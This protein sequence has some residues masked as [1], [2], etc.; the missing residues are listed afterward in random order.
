MDLIDDRAVLD[1]EEDDESFDEETGEVREKSNGANGHFD[2]SSEEEEDDDDEEAAAEV[3]K[4]FIVDEDEDDEETRRERRRERKKRRREE[5]EDEGLDEEDLELIGLKPAEEAPEPKFKRLKRGP[6]EDRDVQ[7]PY[8][9]NDIFGHSDEEEEAVDYSRRTSR[10]DRRGLQ[11]EFDDFIE[12]DVF[13]DEEQQRQ[14]EDEEV[15]RPNRRGLP[16][17]GIADAAGLDEQALEDFRAAFGDGTDYDFALEKEDEADEEEAERD[18]HLD[19]KDVF[20]P[21]Q[22]AEKMLTDEDNTIRYTDEAE[23]HQ[24]A[25][26]PYRHVELSEDEFK[27]EA[28]WISN[29]MLP[30]KQFNADLHEPFRRAV[31]QVLE[32][33]VRDDYEVPFIFQNR[34]DYLL[35]VVQRVVGRE[36]DGTPRTVSDATRL[37]VQRDLWQIFEHDLKYRALIEKRQ[38]LRKAYEDLKSVNIPEDVMFQEMLPLAATMEELQDLQDYLYFQYASRLK[39]LALTSHGETNGINMSQK[40]AATKTVYEEIRGAKAYGLV[41]AFGITA[42]AFAQ[43]AARKGVRTY[44]EDPTDNPENLADTF[45]DGEFPTGSRVLKAAKSMF[46]EELVMSPRFRGLIR[47]NVYKE[48]VIDC[49]RTEKG[50]RK[51][52][53]QHPYYEFKYLRNQ[54][55]GSFFQRPDLFLKM[56]KAE[57]EGLVE[58]Q[59]RLRNNEN[60]KKQL[61]KHIETDNYSN[62][63]D[64]W[65]AER[66]EVI[67]VAVD[68]VMKLMGRLV[69]EN[70]KEQCEN[71]IGVECREEFN[72]R[73]DQAP[74]QPRGMKKGTTPRVLTLS[75]GGGVPGRDMIYW[76]FVND[77]GRVLEHGRFKELGPGDRE[78]GIPDGKDVEALLEVIRR[79]EPEVIGVSGWCPDTRKLHSNLVTLVKNHDL[80]G[81][82]F[83]D[84]D[85]R[86]RSELLEVVMVNDEVARMYQT[87]DR[88]KL[89]HPGFPQLALYCV[90]L[91]RYLQDPLKEYAALGRD[92]V[93]VSF[94]PAQNLL[95]QEKLLKKLEMALVDNVNMVGVDLNEAASDTAV[96]NLLPYVAGLGPRKA[97]HL[98][99]VIHLNGG[100]VNTR[101]DLLG[102]N[103]LHAAMGFKVWSNAAATLYIQF[104]PSEPTSEY[105]DN[106][107]VHPEDYDIARKMAADALEL[108]EEDIEAERQE[109]GSG[110]IV[111]RLIREEAQERVNDLVLEEYAEQLE[112]NL[113]SKKH[114]TLE[115]IRAELIEPYEELRNP[116]RSNLG[117][118]E[119]F[120]MLT[121]ETRDS[122][123]RGMNVPIS[124][125]KITDMHVEGKLDSGLDAVVEEG[126]WADSTVS[127]KQ[128]YTLHQT[129]Q[130]HI[131]AINRK[132]FTVSVSLRDDLLKKPFK[133]YNHSDR[134][135]DEW[136][137][138]EEAADKKLLEEKTDSGN[139]AA[140]V[141]KHPLFRPFNAKQAEE[142]LG[143]QNR[144]D[145]VI[146]PSSKG[147]DHLAVTWKVADGIFQHI[148][149]L[150][151]DKENEFSLGRT[152]RIGGRYNYSDLDEL[153]VLHVK[154]MARKVDEM[155]G[156]EKFQDKSKAA[157]EEWLT[158]Y[159]NANPK[160]SMYQFCINRERPGQFHLVFK[161]GQNAKLMDWA[162]RVI[163]QGFELMK[164]PYPTMRDLCNGFKLIF[165]NM[166]EAATMGRG[167]RR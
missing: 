63:A 158:T 124:L 55:F 113:N 61:N 17:L 144:G 156:N 155:C 46:I 121:G 37:L 109:G 21:S 79:R 116:F 12:E 27:E 140:R 22:L 130:A 164:Q 88:A 67:S 151:L 14:L 95:P 5:R 38:A 117:E 128:L 19:L 137:D 48:G 103:D 9:V 145:V 132:E 89:D 107:R 18:K 62:V 47:E 68:K 66:R 167:V 114:T 74:Y 129:V 131:T 41:R 59:V 147:T 94:H 40:K 26:K 154:A 75:N 149:V 165:Q 118:S 150:E 134:S 152:L 84:E 11:D 4:G 93:S 69:K 32:F 153:I 92:I 65:N 159:T 72:Q 76:A 39:D 138:R 52:D 160:R 105:L 71:N 123:Q 99:K 15:A 2:D 106:T 36:E 143:S 96:A 24:L 90:A 20:E 64:A 77:D 97:S 110:A 25:R 119:I 112:K 148:D 80:H 161:A 28:V 31:A 73:L 139:R 51:I 56:L 29:L 81:P 122:L 87:S 44:T 141:I 115:N 135:Y 60:F 50:L 6:R 10:P 157:L 23:R 33:L 43:N 34:K 111:R 83:S 102:I 1:D 126:Q 101:E 166:H 70:L 7:Q 162:V 86:D 42:D 98:L 85:D 3:A 49:H 108:D 82:T 104:D 133:R 58:I 125:K 57:E 142:Y 163:P 13:S 78:R 45:I 100:Y 120:T 91:G 16:D 53:E 8:G 136:D 54:N 146:R 35:H 30:S 127:P